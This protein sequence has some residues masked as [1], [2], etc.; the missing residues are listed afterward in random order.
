MKKISKKDYE[1]LVAA[2][3]HV[4]RIGWALCEGCPMSA[5]RNRL[6]EPCWAF[7]KIIGGENVRKEAEIHGYST[8]EA[9]IHYMIKYGNPDRKSI[10]I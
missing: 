2:A 1:T 5:E 7:M 10:R 6:G 9:A 8:Q 3:E 4:D